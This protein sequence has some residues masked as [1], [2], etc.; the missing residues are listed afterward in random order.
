MLHP[1]EISQY[2]YGPSPGCCICWAGYWRGVGDERHRY[3]EQESGE[4]S[5]CP[6]ASRSG[7]GGA[8]KTGVAEKARA[9]RGRTGSVRRQARPEPIWENM[10][11]FD[12]PYWS[13][14]ETYREQYPAVLDSRTGRPGF[15]PVWLPI[16]VS[17][18][19]PIW[20]S[21]SPTQISSSPFLFGGGK[22]QGGVECPDR[23]IRQKGSHPPTANGSHDED[24]WSRK[25]MVRGFPANGPE[26]HQGTNP[27]KGKG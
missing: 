9:G 1:G 26:I 22:A 6:G 21:Y 15:F 7:S 10:G 11:S 17:G 8:S 13:T 20:G 4:E 14:L 12:E 27:T 24:W 23:G 16:Q 25:E 3:P 2:R 5:Q 19:S 18:H